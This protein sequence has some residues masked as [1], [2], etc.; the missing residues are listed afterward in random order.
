VR[1]T[2]PMLGL[3]FSKPQAVEARALGRLWAR[4]RFAL[5]STWRAFYARDVSVEDPDLAVLAAKEAAREFRRLLIAA[6]S[7]RV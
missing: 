1:V 4:D 6:P 3:S 7:A 5:G 2:R